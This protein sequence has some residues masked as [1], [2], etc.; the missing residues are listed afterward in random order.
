MLEFNNFFNFFQKI[1]HPHTEQLLSNWLKRSFEL[2]NFSGTTEIIYF[3]MKK[4]CLMKILWDLN[5]QVENA[6]YWHTNVQKPEYIIDQNYFYQLYI[7]FML[8]K[9]F[10]LR[11]TLS[12]LIGRSHSPAKK[13]NLEFISEH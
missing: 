12:S 1:F 7:Y 2:L 10:L 13:K 9:L 3:F 8:R 11:L 4:F 6:I 5:V